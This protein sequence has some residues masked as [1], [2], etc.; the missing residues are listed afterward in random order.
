MNLLIAL[1]AFHPWWCFWCHHHPSPTPKPTPSPTATAMPTPT[2]TATPTPAGT[3]APIGLLGLFPAYKDPAQPKP[4][5]NRCQTLANGNAQGVLWRQTWQLIEKTEGSYDWSYLDA[6][7]AASSAKGKIAALQILHSAGDFGPPQWLIDK[8]C[9]MFLGCTVPWDPIFQQYWERFQ[10]AMAAR[11]KDRTDLVYVVTAG[12]GH[13]SES[14]FVRMTEDEAAADVVAKRAGFTGLPQAWEI[15]AKWIVDMYL[16]VWGKDI[17]YTTG[18]PFPT[19]GQLSQTHVVEYGYGKAPTRFGARPNNLGANSPQPFEPSV[20]L[21][22]LTAPT[23]RATG[24]QYGQSQGTSD[25]LAQALDR[26][27]SY[28]AHFQELFEGD[29]NKPE[30]QTVIKASLDKIGIPHP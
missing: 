27:W 9:V 12:Q 2:A 6:C 1:I 22:K 4:D 29:L 16:R 17:V 25:P 8:G 10:T 24:F 20:V 15:G 18:A 26:G 5:P 23:C 14:F 28:G 3:P 7:F 13:A 11:Y 19:D 21:V 30:N